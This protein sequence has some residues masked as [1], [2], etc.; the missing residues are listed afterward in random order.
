V[1]EAARLLANSIV[2]IERNP[3]EISVEAE[4]TE[5]QMEIEK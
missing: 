4:Q 1:K 5:R 2:K 3:F